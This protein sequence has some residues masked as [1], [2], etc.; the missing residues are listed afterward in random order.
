MD[1]CRRS[2]LINENVTWREKYSRLKDI[3]VLAS[4]LGVQ[5]RIEKY[6]SLYWCAF[7]TKDVDYSHYDYP[8]ARIKKYVP[9][10]DSSLYEDVV[11]MREHENMLKRELACY[12]MATA[13]LDKHKK[14]YEEY[15]YTR[16][17]KI[18]LLD[19]VENTY[20]M[21]V[22]DDSHQFV[23]DGVITHNSAAHCLLWSFCKIQDTINELGLETKICGQ[24]HDSIL[25]DIPHDELDDVL[26]LANDIMTRQLR[27][28]YD[29]IVVP[30]EIEA[31]VAPMGKS[32]WD[33][34]DYEISE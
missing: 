8:V 14:E 15:R 3:A 30:M 34:E 11:E 27:E 21:S 1:D 22:N 19:A 23:A 4:G 16:I 24:I 5:S 28:H 31:A 12:G 7:F 13:V 33:K 25:L 20:T 2:G 26:R 18:K 6:E 9:E 10:I 29:W 17:K 32:W